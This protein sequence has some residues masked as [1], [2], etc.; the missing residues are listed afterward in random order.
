[1]ADRRKL[2]M[3]KTREILRLVL[4]HGMAKRRIAR[5][6]AISHST[7]CDTICRANAAGLD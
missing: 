3:R 1:M 4:V 6:L 5:S 2:S 7:V